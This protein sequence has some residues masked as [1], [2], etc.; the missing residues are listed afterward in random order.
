MALR[1]KSEWTTTAELS[2]SSSGRPSVHVAARQWQH[3]L[4]DVLDFVELNDDLRPGKTGRNGKQ[5]PTVQNRPGPPLHDHEPWPVAD[6]EQNAA[7]GTEPPEPVDPVQ[8][9]D[10][11]RVA[12]IREMLAHSCGARVEPAWDHP[13]DEQDGYWVSL[14]E[15]DGQPM[16][17]VANSG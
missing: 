7:Q 11:V 1:S 15:G 8:D 17:V 12:D 3:L 13:P 4:P 5:K 14:C 10:P 6:Q 9:L 16:C 2:R